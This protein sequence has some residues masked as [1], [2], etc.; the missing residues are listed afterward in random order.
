MFTRYY[1]DRHYPGSKIK[2]VPT[3]VTGRNGVYWQYAVYNS[4][5]LKPDYLDNYFPPPQTYHAETID[6]VTVTAIVK[7]TARLDYKA[8]EALKAAKHHLADS[9]YETYMRTTNDR[10]AALFAY[11]SIV[12]G[13]LGRNDE[14]IQ[15]ANNC[16]QYHFSTVLDYNAYCGL[17]IAYCNKREY[18]LSVANLQ[19]AM[20]I[21]PN[22]TYAKDI[23]RQVEQVIQANGGMPAK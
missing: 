13:S 5:F 14:A 21:L 18:Q 1:I 22:E 19:N 20:R 11:L 3:G 16:L 6:G 17:G 12:K 2:V 23:M 10:N 4:L 9:L 8:L 15:L 7:D